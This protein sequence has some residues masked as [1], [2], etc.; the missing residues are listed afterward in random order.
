[1][2]QEKADGPIEGFQ[3][4]YSEAIKEKKKKNIIIIKLKILGWQE[5]NCR[6]YT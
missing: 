6:F 3:K 2:I 5:S 1:M 4:S